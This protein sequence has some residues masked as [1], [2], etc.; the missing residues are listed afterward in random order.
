[1]ACIHF[2][3]IFVLSKVKKIRLTTNPSE[4][5]MHVFKELIFDRP[6]ALK[7]DFLSKK[8]PPKFKNRFEWMKDIKYYRTQRFDK[9]VS[10]DKYS[11][12]YFVSNEKLTNKAKLV[13]EEEPMEC[14]YLL[15]Q[16]HQ[17][18][19][20]EITEPLKNIMN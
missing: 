14:G 13:Y 4:D 18:V 15:V 12:T 1:M 3:L 6:T 7:L 17:S 11:L 2:I 10:K 16:W 5:A 8:M 19:T 20:K 9:K